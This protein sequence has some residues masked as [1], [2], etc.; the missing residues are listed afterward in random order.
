MGRNGRYLRNRDEILNAA[1]EDTQPHGALENEAL[2][3]Q[4]KEDETG[5]AV[6]ADRL[7]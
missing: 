4:T 2:S 3:L 1:I 7:E 5:D 6:T